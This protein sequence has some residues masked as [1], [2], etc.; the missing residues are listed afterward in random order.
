MPSVR[1]IHWNAEE[2]EGRASR[3]STAGHDVAFEPF[4]P[5]LLRAMRTNLP[6]AIVIDLSRLPSQ[7]RDVGLAL[8]KNAATRNV[9]LVFVE[10]D[11][12]KVKGVK[13]HLP[14][15][16]YATWKGI[17]GTLKKAI[18]KPPSDP[19]VPGSGMEAYA[20][21]PLPKKLG[22]KPG[23]VICLVGA[24]KDFGDTLGPLPEGVVLKR[25]ARGTSDLTIWFVKS[26]T[27]LVDR[28]P[29]MVPRGESAG[30][31]IAWPKKASGVKT[32]ITQN[33]VRREGLAAGLVDFKICSIDNTWSGLRFTARQ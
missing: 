10:G 26:K 18:S 8:R 22:I 27:Q 2:A 14:D 19:V 21:T 9:P 6:S 13:R 5:K 12:D 23:T 17:R 15:A 3:L 24:P 32:D 28:L 25:Q 4:T 29:R 33:D 30:L 31:W 1:L 16:A 7:G 11:T 20:G